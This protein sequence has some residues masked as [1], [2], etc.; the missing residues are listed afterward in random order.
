MAVID[1]TSHG[2]S[3][4]GTTDDHAAVLA[5]IRRVDDAGGGTVYF[6]AG[7]Y[8]LSAPIGNGADGFTRVHLL[9]DGE[10]GARLK[11]TTKAPPISGTWVESRIENLTIDADGHGAP[12]LDVDLD[13]SYVRHCRIRGWTDYG[14][15]VNA[16]A[17]GLLNW[18]DDNFVEQGTGYGI[19]TTHRFF[20][21]WI[22]NN[23]V[24][25]TGPNLSI[26][27][28]PVR[29]IANHLDGTPQ[30]NIELR[31]NKQ[32]TIIGNICEG[33]RKEAIVF[34]MPSWMTSDDEQ[35]AIV[36]NNITNGGKGAPN[37]HPAIGIYSLDAER[38]TKGFNIT[39]N[40]IANTDEGAGWSY[41]VDA[42]YVDDIAISGNQWDNNGY[43]VAPVRAQGRNVGIA[44]NTSGNR[45][46]PAQRTVVTLS[47]DA[48]LDD[49][50]GAE[51][52]YL[53]APGT[54]VVLLPTAADNSCRYTVKNIAAATVTLRTHPG[55]LI[56]GAAEFA[57]AAGAAVNLLSD[58]AAWW[59]V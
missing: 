26:E 12:G 14:M 46:V 30:H 43:S 1:V 8:A 49:A 20:D 29:I 7:E 28:G 21:S 40:F 58:G 42:Q 55:Q 36:G 2:A 17:E 25:S 51:Y 54:S 22:V 37:V 27:S 23:N 44:G 56:D 35:V 45:P 34:T 41:A 11:A 9:G 6:P 32:L 52:V 19:Y 13:K 4:D 59:V 31:G 10:R 18:I 5:A 38:R 24:G 53:L 15:R 48:T 47:A 57:L 3:G 50:P 33:A 16:R 39:G